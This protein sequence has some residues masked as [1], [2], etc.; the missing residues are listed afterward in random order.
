MWKRDI[1]TFGPMD[2]N[3]TSNINDYDD[4]N[5]NI[6]DYNSNN[7]IGLGLGLLLLGVIIWVYV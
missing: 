3:I 2:S 6:N 1:N 4:N 5:D 7:N